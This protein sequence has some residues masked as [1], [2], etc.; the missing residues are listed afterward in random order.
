MKVSYWKLIKEII[1]Y[2]NYDNI[3]RLSAA[4]AYYTIFS[5]APFLFICITIAGLVFGNNSAQQAILTQISQLI[6]PGSEQQVELMLNSISHISSNLTIN[7]T[8]LIILFLGMIGFFSELQNGI[9][10][11]WG[12]QR[13]PG[14]SYLIIFRIRLLPFIVILGLVF[15]L[16]AS[17]V[18]DTFITA[19]SNY[20]NV[21]IAHVSFALTLVNFFITLCITTFLFTLIFK[22][23]P[24]V[25]LKWKDVWIGSIVTAFLFTI[26]K[27]ILEIYLANSQIATSY[28]AA[29]ALIAIL[30]WVYYSAQILFIGA[31]FIKV[32]MIL[33]EK[34]IIPYQYAELI[35]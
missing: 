6:G 2:W 20:L 24:D 35:K 10:T 34:D 9:N 4:L 30:I 5:I 8:T 29:G 23:L 18:I 27:Y 19:I 7:I 26:G 32:N 21:L 3:S 13:R 15:L 11:I 25:I 33:R 28:G 16:L 14:L 17:L 31:E 22:I 1:T 12:V